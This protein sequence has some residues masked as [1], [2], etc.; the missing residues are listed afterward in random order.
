MMGSKWYQ[1]DGNNSDVVLFSKIRLAR[2]LA[3]SPFP[4]RMSAELRK[5]VSKKLYA[6]VKSSPLANE[7]DMINLSDITTA[8]AASYCERQLISKEHLKN[9][10]QASFMLSKNEDVSIMLCEEDHIRINAFE[11]GQNLAAAYKKADELDD[12]FISSLKLAFSEK[13]GFLTAS[14]INLGT[15]LKASFALHL[16]ALRNSNSIYKL[17]SMVGKLGLSLREMF[18]DGAGD[19]YILSNQVS[20]GISEKSA[21]DNL[22]AICDQI[23]KQER[24]AR[25]ALKE[26]IDFEDKIFRTLG[27]LKTARKLDT[28]EFLNNLSALRLGVSLG[29]FDVEY[30]TIGEM[31]FDLQNASLL[32]SAQADLSQ[33]M[34]EKLRAQIIR[35]KLE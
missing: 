29:Y 10:E 13:L 31:L 21:I 7:F 15:G 24:T 11:A 12:I 14:P 25:E 23:V 2:N 4:E 9:K 35:E 20:L 30:Q 22:S 32:D 6:A 27:I 5:S 18:K 26:N 33:P 34:L 3:D 16:P 17:S 8:K 28:D 1:L 19:I